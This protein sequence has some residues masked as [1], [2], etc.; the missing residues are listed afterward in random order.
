MQGTIVVTDRGGSRAPPGGA[1][2]GPSRALLWPLAALV[3]IA[4]AG[5]WLSVRLAFRPVVAFR[6]ALEARGRGNLTPVGT[7]G[8]PRGDGARRGGGERADRPPAG[9]RWRR[10][11]ASP[12]T[13]RTNCARPSP[14]RWPRRSGSSPNCPTTPRRERAR[15]IAAS[16]RRLSRLS[17]KLL[18][19]AKA[20]GG[21]LI[22]AD[23]R[24]RSGPCCDSSSTNCAARPSCGDRIDLV[25]LGRRTTVSDLDP[26]AFAILARNLIENALRHGDPDEPVS[27]DAG[28][29]A[30]WRSPT[31]D[32]R[33]RRSAWRR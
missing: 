18:Q 16:L 2:C 5:V 26:D 11:A 24:R 22:A 12:P 6:A 20:E 30:C 7:T 4:V 23:A 14:R 32:P 15:A 29:R 27:V 25:G 21:G 1:V 9:A 19:L 33:C 13:A 3:P 8:L 31:A 10:S 17:E 28:G